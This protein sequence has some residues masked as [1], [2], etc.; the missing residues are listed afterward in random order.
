MCQLMRGAAEMVLVQNDLVSV[1]KDAREQL[2]NLYFCLSHEHGQAEAICRQIE[3]L[4]DHGLKSFLDGKK[5][6]LQ[7]F[8]EGS[9]AGTLLR[10]W[11]N[12]AET[13][14]H[15]FARWHVSNTR[16]APELRLGEAPPIRIQVEYIRANAEGIKGGSKKIF[17]GGLSAANNGN[18]LPQT[19]EHVP[20]ARQVGVHS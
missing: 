10:K 16:Y 20:L 13:M 9:P 8:A 14:C 1:A 4:H 3:K 17:I 12:A 11:I 5:I 15:G 7:E 18:N 2:L 19:R 6:L